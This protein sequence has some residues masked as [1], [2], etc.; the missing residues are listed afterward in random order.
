MDVSKLFAHEREPQKYRLIESR[1]FRDR[2][3]RCDDKMFT[4]GGS[5]KDFDRGPFTMSRLD[6]TASNRQ[7]FDDAVA[8]GV[9]IF[10]PNHT[11]HP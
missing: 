1:N 10:G 3:L 8:Q 6:T 9:E 2:W 4:L 7:H 5:I 11:S